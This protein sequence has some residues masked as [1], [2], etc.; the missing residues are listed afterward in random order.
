MSHITKRSQSTGLCEE[1]NLSKVH[2]PWL[3]RPLREA[4]NPFQRIRAL[5]LIMRYT[6]VWSYLHLKR[7]ASLVWGGWGEMV[8]TGS[9]FL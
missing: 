6:Q 1:M 9:R 3:G 4:P 8:H 7:Q 2:D 5:P